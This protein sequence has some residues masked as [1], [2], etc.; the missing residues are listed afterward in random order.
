ME[1]K[2]RFAVCL[3]PALCSAG[4]GGAPTAQ[5]HTCQG[6]HKVVPSHQ[7]TRGVPWSRHQP[8]AAP[9]CHTL[10]PALGLCSLEKPS[11]TCASPATLR[12]LF[13]SW[14]A[15]FVFCH[16]EPLPSLCVSSIYCPVPHLSSRKGAL[17][18]WSPLVCPWSSGI[19]SLPLL[20]CCLS[21]PPVTDN[22]WLPHAFSF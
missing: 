7:R 16:L 2:P 17:S 10:S 22:F 19:W 1:V 6:T 21:L 3:P 15:C 8:L 4:T 9:S 5:A 18:M 11:L 12:R 20:V 14:E 13:L